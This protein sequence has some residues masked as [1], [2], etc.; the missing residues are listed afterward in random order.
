MRGPVGSSGSRVNST[1]A[2]SAS[3]SRCTTTA[4][5]S[6]ASSTPCRCRYATARSV[7]SDGQQ[8]STASQQRRPRP[9]RRG[10]FPAGRRSWCRPRPRPSP[11]TARRP[12]RR[13]ARGRR[14]PGVRAS[15]GV[16]PRVGP[17]PAVGGR[18]DAEARRA[19]AG[20]PTAIRPRLSPL[21]PTRSASADRTRSNE[22]MSAIQTGYG[23]AMVRWRVEP[24][25]E[26]A[27]GA[28]FG[29]QFRF[30]E[31]ESKVT[32]GDAFRCA[33]LAALR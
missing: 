3:T 24:P 15:A 30:T 10:S 16:D 13:R 27:F 8:R 20:R 22:R 2:T 14:R 18:G 17:E 25:P 32:Y 26:R 5:A 28:W 9:R 7:S 6:P 21:P 4:I 11:T 23:W 19:P 12:A 29:D 31:P 33:H 1:P